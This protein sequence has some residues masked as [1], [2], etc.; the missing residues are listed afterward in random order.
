MMTVEASMRRALLIV[1][2]LGGCAASKE[3]LENSAKG[4]IS[5]LIQAAKNLD[6]QKSDAIAVAY[7]LLGACDSEIRQAEATA[8]QGTNFEGYQTVKRRMNEFFLKAA[9]EIV[10]KERSQRSQRDK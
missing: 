10:L 5:C 7:G 2:A 8:A 3:E 1:L 9:T 6:D 4:T